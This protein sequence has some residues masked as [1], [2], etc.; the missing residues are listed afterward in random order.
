[1]ISNEN[2]L[3]D[4]LKDYMDQSKILEIIRQIHAEEEKWKYNRSK[5][6]KSLKNDNKAQSIKANLPPLFLLT[7]TQKTSDKMKTNYKLTR[8]PNQTERENTEISRKIKQYWDRVHLAFVKIEKK[9][10]VI[11]NRAKLNEAVYFSEPG[12]YHSLYKDLDSQFVNHQSSKCDLKTEFCPEQKLKLNEDHMRCVDELMELEHQIGENQTQARAQIL[13]KYQHKINYYWALKLFLK[14]IKL[15]K[16]K[17]VTVKLQSF[18]EIMIISQWIRALSALTSFPKILNISI[19]MQILKLNKLVS[20]QTQ[21]FDDQMSFENI[22]LMGQNQELIIDWILSFVSKSM[23]GDSM[24][25]END[26]ENLFRCCAIFLTDFNKRAN[27][28]FLRHLDDEIWIQKKNK[29]DSSQDSLEQVANDKV[30]NSFGFNEIDSQDEI[31]RGNPHQPLQMKDLVESWDFDAFVDNHV[32]NFEIS[33]NPEL[34]SILSRMFD[35]LK[36]LQKIQTILKILL[37]CNDEFKLEKIDWITDFNTSNNSKLCFIKNFIVRIF[38][39]IKKNLSNLPSLQ[40]VNLQ[41]APDKNKFEYKNYDQHHFYIQFCDELYRYSLAHDFYAEKT[42]NDF[43]EAILKDTLKKLKS[44]EQSSAVQL[45]DKPELTKCIS[46]IRHFSEQYNSI[47]ETLS[48][49]DSLLVVDP[50]KTIERILAGFCGKELNSSAFDIETFETLKNRFDDLE[51]I[52]QK[53]DSVDRLL[54]KVKSSKAVV[55][56]KE[57]TGKIYSLF[58]EVLSSRSQNKHG[59]FGAH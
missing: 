7:E 34:A 6:A 47:S 43:F 51:K 36:Q 56:G 24:S 54:E 44:A 22:I 20:F 35:Y 5:K 23:E 29:A 31:E 19:Q 49:S 28:Y 15:K 41:F 52:T 4:H 18:Y 11:Y 25:A 53:I 10:I 38:S 1:M 46:Q 27:D 30:D 50:L 48:E 16:Q 17:Q 3:A 58:K 57:L 55:S 12:F 40:V 21:T 32:F 42:K 9:Y 13:L 33:L 59:R 14:K 45:S 26:F 39:L 37:F 8:L 2:K